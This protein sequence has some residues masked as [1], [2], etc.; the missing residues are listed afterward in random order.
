[1]FA[2]AHTG[3]PSSQHQTDS[4]SIKALRS[5]DRHPKQELARLGSFGGAGEEK[6]RHASATNA[7]LILS[8]H[9]VS[10]VTSLSA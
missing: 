4:C 2:R 6:A 5:T 3:S 8:L 10:L 1:M 9:V 7:N